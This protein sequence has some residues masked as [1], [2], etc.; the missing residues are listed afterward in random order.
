MDQSLFVDAT[1]VRRISHIPGNFFGVL[2][3]MAP[4]EVLTL[5]ILCGTR[6]LMVVT[7]LCFFFSIERR[8]PSQKLLFLHSA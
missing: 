1:S 6:V 2:V 4:I 3:S 7:F 5:P 8:N